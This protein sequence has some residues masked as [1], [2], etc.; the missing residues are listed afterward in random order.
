[1]PATGPWYSSIIAASK[2]K[3]GAGLAAGKDRAGNPMGGDFRANSE[4][5]ATHR[6]GLLDA[7][8]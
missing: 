2:S 4:G 8:G 6:V 5:F 3:Q 7:C 1:M